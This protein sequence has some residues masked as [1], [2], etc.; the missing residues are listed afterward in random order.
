MEKEQIEIEEMFSGEELAIICSS[1]LECYTHYGYKIT[2]LKINKL[3]A[4]DI[5]EAEAFQQCIDSYTERHNV[6][7][8]FLSFMHGS[9]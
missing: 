8:K 2:E 3:K 5:E 4:N 9:C 1:L 7:G 6:L